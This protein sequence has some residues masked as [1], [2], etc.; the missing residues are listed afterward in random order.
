MRADLFK[1]YPELE[2][3]FDSLEGKFSNELC[4]EMNYMIDVENKD[5]YKVAYDY[6][7]ENGFLS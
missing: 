6:L 1:D 4:T 2:E 7:K 3:V 5:P